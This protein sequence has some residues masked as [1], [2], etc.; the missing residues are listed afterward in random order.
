MLKYT[1]NKLNT[2]EISPFSINVPLLYPLKIENRRFS[3]VFRGYR[4]ET[5]ENGVKITYANRMLID[6]ITCWTR[7]NRVSYLLCKH[8][9]SKYFSYFVTIDSVILN[10][11]FYAIYIVILTKSILFPSRM[12]PNLTRKIRVWWWLFIW[13][14]WLWIRYILPNHHLFV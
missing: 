11:L 12:F 14:L 7:I 1:R 13:F 5:I 6:Y 10:W 9:Y 3:D 2:L 4:N 8:N